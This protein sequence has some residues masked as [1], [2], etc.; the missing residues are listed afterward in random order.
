MSRN[1]DSKV[2]YS[3]T[4]NEMQ[5]YDEEVLDIIFG[6][7]CNYTWCFT[8]TDLRFSEKI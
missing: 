7:D 8:E 3:A 1:P 4:A 2:L 5:M 6:F